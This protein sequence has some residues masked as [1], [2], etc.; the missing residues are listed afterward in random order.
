MLKILQNAIHR[1]TSHVHL[2]K[3][4]CITSGFFFLSKTPASIAT[5]THG[6]PNAPCPLIWT[7]VAHSASWSGFRGSEI[8]V[9]C[10][11]WVPS[12]KAQPLHM[13]F[14]DAPQWYIYLAKERITWQHLLQLKNLSQKFRLTA[15]WHPISLWY[16]H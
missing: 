5:Y 9:L 11:L 16:F 2:H 1:E 3:T 4:S 15:N 13:L 10:E 6:R 14:R 7:A 12:N 8:R